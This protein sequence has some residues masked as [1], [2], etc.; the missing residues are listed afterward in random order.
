[1]IRDDGWKDAKN[2]QIKKE[3]MNS[4]NNKTIHTYFF[5]LSI[6]FQEYLE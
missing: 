1:M 3:I 4:I 5:R 6:I 2:P